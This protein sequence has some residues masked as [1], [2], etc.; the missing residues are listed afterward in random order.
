MTPNIPLLFTGQVSKK[1][2]S[3]S[4]R[5]NSVSRIV[6]PCPRSCLMGFLLLLL[7]L[8]GDVE[9]NPGPMSKQEAASLSR[10]EEMVTQLHAGQASVFSELTN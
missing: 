2:L 7:V 8:S 1:E 3:C 6:L 4:V 10:I 5:S 9:R